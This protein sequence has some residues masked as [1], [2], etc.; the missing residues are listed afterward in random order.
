[1]ITGENVTDA[2]ASFDE[3]GRPQVNITLDAKGG[4]QMGYATRDNIGRR[5][6]VLFIEYKTR[7]EKS[8]DEN[9]EVVIT[10]VPFVEKI[11]S[12]WPRFRLSLAS[13]S[14]LPASMAARVL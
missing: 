10:P 12:A 4:W 7:L 8:I 13:S 2:R 14:A 3:N 5:L 9:G 1:M 6:G 11:L